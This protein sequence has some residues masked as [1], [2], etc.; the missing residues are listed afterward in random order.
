MAES[1]QQEAAA[2]ISAKFGK[3]YLPEKPPVYAN[4]KSQDAHEAV[5]PT[6]MEL[7]PRD[8]GRFLNRDQLRLYTL[9]WERFIASQMAPA[10]YDTLAV[11]ISAARYLLRANG[12]E[13]KFAGYLRA[14]E[15]ADGKRGDKEEQDG[16]DE[17]QGK[18]T[19]LPSLE[20]GQKLKL[21]KLIDLQ[22]FTEPP[23][24]YSEA[25][26]VKTLEEKGIGRP[27]TYAPTIETI[28]GRGYVNEWKN[29]FI[30]PI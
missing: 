14:F 15:A 7:A 25:S 22:H 28:V 10:V 24:R 16:G 11:D 23:P 13:L 17:I 6:S 8:I 27:S 30:R 9:I 5:R 12:S 29:G 3:E 26:L 21:N 1:A 4:K 2:H 18:D 20:I 19:I